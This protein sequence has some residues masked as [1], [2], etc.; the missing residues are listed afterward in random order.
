M[1]NGKMQAKYYTLLYRYKICA[2]LGTPGGTTMFD[3]VFV[4]E[5]A[6][7]IVAKLMPQIHNPKN[8]S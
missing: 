3:E 7:Q 4:T 1:E 2:I 6:S 8:G 5:L